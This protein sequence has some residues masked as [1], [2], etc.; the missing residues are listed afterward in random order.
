[1]LHADQC[2][3][4]LEDS[5]MHAREGRLASLRK[6][7]NAELARFLRRLGAELIHRADGAALRNFFDAFFALSRERSNEQS[8]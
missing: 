7:A 3:D 6:R 8:V 1:M 4:A 5:W 2:L